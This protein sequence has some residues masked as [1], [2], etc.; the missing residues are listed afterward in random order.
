MSIQTPPR[1]SSFACL[2]A[3]S[4]LAF[5]ALPAVADGAPLSSSPAP[6]EAGA[7]DEETLLRRGV[8][9]REKGDD[10]GALES[11]HKAYLFSK[12]A[13]A[14][15]QIALAE[16]AL[17]RWV[18]AE[19]H[20]NQALSQG[21]DP[22]ISRNKELLDQSLKDIQ[23]HLGSL[24]LSGGISGAA[25]VVNGSA[26]GT[27]PL[28]TALRVPAGSV[29]IEVRAVGYLPVT[30]M[31]IVPAGGLARETVALVPASPP[32]DVSAASTTPV[33]ADTGSPDT[34][35]VRN[36]PSD[37]WGRRKTTAVALG[38]AG[39]VSLIVGTT[40]LFVRNGRAK[41]FNN[42]G[43]SASDMLPSSNCKSLQDKEHSARIASI[44][45]LAGAGIFGGVAA[46]LLFTD[47][48]GEQPTVALT[49][50]RWHLQCLPDLASVSCSGEF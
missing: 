39:G 37:G 10:Q 6:A 7:T 50:S 11:F 35:A 49:R 41:D 19:G 12:G 3:L 18:E 28:R 15:A 4:F 25:I 13:R 21:D 47:H 32:S 30:R 45:A 44:V 34:A 5:T 16:Q 26:A 27:L 17:G 43:C 36:Q 29:A 42:S 9:L 22:W 23:G 33:A 48:V 40:F 24:E 1:F 8:E 14:L 2:V 46:Y 31:V 38:T 20:L